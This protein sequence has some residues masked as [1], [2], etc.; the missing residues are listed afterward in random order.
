MPDNVQ[1]YHFI[2]I[3]NPYTSTFLSDDDMLTLLKNQVISGQINYHSTILKSRGNEII[4]FHEAID[5]KLD[6]DLPVNIEYL[7]YI[8]HVNNIKESLDV[9][10]DLKLTYLKMFS[11]LMKPL[12]DLKTLENILF[13]QMDIQEERS[14][15]EN[16]VFLPS[17]LTTRDEQVITEVSNDH[18]R[19]ISVGLIIK[20]NK[21]LMIGRSN[22]KKGYVFPKGGCENDEWPFSGLTALREVYEEA[23]C[24]CEIVEEDVTNNYTLSTKR[25]NFFVYKLQ[26]IQYLDD[27]PEKE[28]R[29]NMR[30]WMT[31]EE[32]LDNFND[33]KLDNPKKNL[34]IDMLESLGTHIT[35]VK[36]VDLDSWKD[37][38]IEM[39]LKMKGNDRANLKYEGKLMLSNNKIIEYVPRLDEL[40]SYI[41]TKYESKRWYLSDEE[42]KKY[43][44]NKEIKTE[45]EEIIEK[46]PVQII[47][48]EK[49]TSVSNMIDLNKSFSKTSLYEQKETV[50][51]TELK[52]SI[53][54]LY[55]K[56]K[57]TSAAKEKSVSL[58][59]NDLFKDLI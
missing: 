6:T 24:V 36:S 52:K 55:S 5:Y 2:D 21:I 15:R 22:K 33:M 51:R 27:Y 3:K 23:G 31:F 42:F 4:T 38:D 35:K 13:K 53:L 34:Y 16:Q 46:K 56:P 58:D 30:K 14:G 26:V 47:Q 28:K 10:N 41:K 19:Y 12:N 17:V 1:I 29:S 32:A 44:G 48:E 37:E 8:T 40:R 39:L 18:D 50:D 49:K 25:H 20:D 9:S 57:D 54:A 59:Q 7:N 43:D 11:D 45:Q